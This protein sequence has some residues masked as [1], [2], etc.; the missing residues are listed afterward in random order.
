MQDKLTDIMDTQHPTV[1]EHQP[2]L[3]LLLQG[4]DGLEI[5]LSDNEVP[6]PLFEVNRL[7]RSGQHERARQYFDELAW[8]AVE[9][10][11]VNEPGCT[12]VMYIA[13]RLL[14][15]TGQPEPAERFLR[16]ILD[17]EVHPVVLSDLA[18][19]IQQDPTRKSEAGVYWQ[20]AWELAP[21]NLDYLLEYAFFIWE[22]GGASESVELFEQAIRLA[23]EHSGAELQL[24]WNINYL[25]G[26]DRV[27]IH[28]RAKQWAQK[29][30]G[31]I[32]GF[33]VYANTPCPTRRLKVGL[34]SGDF[35]ENSPL[36]FFEPA[37][38]GICRQAFALYAYSN[39]DRPNVGTERFASLFDVFR[40][41]H[42]QTDHALAEQIRQDGI[43]V[44]IAFGGQ[45]KRHR[46]GVMALKPAPVQVDW[47]GLS[48]LG[49]PQ[50]DYRITD[51]VLDPPEAQPFHTEELVYL[52]DGFVTYQPPPESPPVAP[53]PARV[54]GCV[55]F[56]SFNNHLKINDLVLD[57][58]SQ[59]LQRVPRARMIVKAPGFQDRGLQARFLARMERR[60]I[61][62]GR[63]RLCART[64]YSDYLSLLTQ[65][66]LLL[67]T[68]PFNG[69]RT[70]LEGLWMGVP[71]ITLSGPTFVSRMG[72][73]VMKQ[74]GLDSAFAVPS[75]PAYISR[76]CA[77]VQQ[78]EALADIRSALRDMLLSSSVCDPAGYARALE[79]AFRTMWQQ[80]CE[81]QRQEL[82][83]RR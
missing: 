27:D 64:T 81:K 51:A 66:D 34:V 13:A 36:S 33:S 44:L 23:P 42:A 52:P 75:A 47:G 72:L 71:S 43:D 28:A 76:A 61:A 14:L 50:I 74:L 21:D 38:V 37:L 7:L 58:W 70:T 67:D 24:L 19:L 26:Y 79:G 11:I 45:C 3:S 16:M 54:N 55:T 31:G 46:L 2:R 53:L 22:M 56:G 5:S 80:W 41:V 68:Y 65:V 62:P 63:F 73:A 39:V 59:V 18:R 15:E 57:L 25:P 30:L 6:A 17:L 69:F 32:S 1:T 60:G 82:E 35:I 29:H 4:T 12:D 40:D 10:C 49:F 78:L 48:T 9:D 83:D 77:C 20:R 8:Q